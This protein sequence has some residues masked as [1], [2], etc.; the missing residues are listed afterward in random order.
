MRKLLII[1]LL[2]LSGCSVQLTQSTSMWALC[3]EDRHV[4]A[5]GMYDSDKPSLRCRGGR[6][7]IHVTHILKQEMQ[8]TEPQNDP[9][10]LKKHLQESRD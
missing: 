3:Y 4:L 2:T 7:Q 1:A 5:N 8:N 10:Q 9:L 6:T